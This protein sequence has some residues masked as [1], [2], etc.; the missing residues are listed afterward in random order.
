MP[1]FVSKC[2][3]VNEGHVKLKFV[4]DV[5]HIKI[6]CLAVFMRLGG[7]SAGFEGEEGDQ[8]YCKLFHNRKIRCAIIG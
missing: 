4:K 8:E 6:V 2:L 7:L 5:S 3:A 1:G